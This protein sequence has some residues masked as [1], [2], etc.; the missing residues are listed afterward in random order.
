ETALRYARLSLIPS[1]ILLLL[2]PYNFF[3]PVSNSNQPGAPILIAVMGCL[4]FNAI[5]RRAEHPSKRPPVSIA[6]LV[7]FLLGYALL[8]GAIAVLRHLNFQDTSSFDVALYN[9]I[10]WNIIHGRFFQSSISGSNFVTH[11]SPFLILLSPMYAIFPHPGTLQVIKSIF[12]AAS[13]VPFY[14][15]L[16]RLVSPKAIWPLLIAYLFYPFLVGQHFNAPH[17]ICF[18]PPFLLFAFYFFLTRRFKTFLIFLFLCLSVK[19]HMAMVSMMFGLYALLLRRSRRWVLTP[20]VIGGLWAV[21]SLWL[22]HHFQQIYTV[23]PYPAWLI[24]NIK[25]R[26]LRPGYPIGENLLWGMETSVLKNVYALMFLYML[27]APVGIIFPLLSAIPLLGL[28]ELLISLA[29]SIPLFYPTWHYNIVVGCFIMVACAAVIGRIGKK[30][31]FSLPSSKVQQLCA[32]FICLCVLSHSF[33]WQNYMHIKRDPA[34]LAVMKEAI[35]L[36][37][38]EASVS[39][40]KHLVSHVSTR[41]DYFLLEDDRKGDY[42]LIDR[43]KTVERTVPSDAGPA[44]YKTIFEKNGVRVYGRIEGDLSTP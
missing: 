40:P 35:A 1:F 25:G 3:Y 2:I 21:F 29:A 15:I 27:F 38:D 30:P 43:D 19:E 16:K 36:I 7:L 13:A 23:D 37:P 39:A 9:Q 10:Q 22:I 34:Y 18:L 42:I 12:L 44:H 31:H 5:L 24:D 20:I 26:F 28:P 14:L 11:N 33:L 41:D 32:W 4:I 8:F 17:E 6:L